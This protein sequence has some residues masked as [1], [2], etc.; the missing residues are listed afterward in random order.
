MTWAVRMALCDKD[1]D[2]TAA[3]I[4]LPQRISDGHGNSQ[5]DAA[6]ELSVDGVDNGN[7]ARGLHQP[8]APNER[9]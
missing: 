4:Q 3:E 5:A 1:N 2:T 7:R 9:V 6:V 8:Q